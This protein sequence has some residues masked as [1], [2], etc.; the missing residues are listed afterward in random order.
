MR[1]SLSLPLFAAIVWSSPIK[2]I[3]S[4]PF[5][6]KSR[7][8]WWPGY[9]T[10]TRRKC[11]DSPFSW[12]KA[13]M[14][15]KQS[16]EKSVRIYNSAVNEWIMKRTHPNARAMFTFTCCFEYNK[17][18]QQEQQMWT[19]WHVLHSCS[20]HSMYIPTSKAP[21]PHHPSHDPY[22]GRCWRLTKTSS[23]SPYKVWH[24]IIIM[25]LIISTSFHCV[26]EI[27]DFCQANV[28]SLSCVTLQYKHV[29]VACRITL[30][31]KAV[32]PIFRRES[33][34]VHQQ[35]QKKLSPSFVMVLSLHHPFEYG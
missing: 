19:L 32:E 22:I 12:Y 27:S 9:T 23:S 11:L 7:A 31:R 6:H 1:L 15:C 35:Q 3:V 33:F 17:Q 29:S 5:F 34:S 28:N 13:L 24:I 8:S 21:P 16:F 30:L 25:Q 18:Q 4:F 20:S 14:I 26:E 2:P 10:S